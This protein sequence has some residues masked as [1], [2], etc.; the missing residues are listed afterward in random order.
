M[1]NSA[2]GR[3]ALALLAAALLAFAAGWAAHDGG[4][5]DWLERMTVDARFSLRGRQAPPASVVVVGIDENSLGQLPRFPFPRIWHARAIDAL[6]RAG[7][8]LIV[9]DVAFDRASDQ[10]DDNALKQAARQAAPV[11]F[12]TSEIGPSGATEVLE[13]N[14]ALAAIGARAAAADLPYDGDGVLRHTLDQI[15]HLPTVAAAVARQLHVPVDERQLRGG[16]IDFPGRPGTVR[17]LSFA[18]V[19]RGH[20][21]PAAVRGKIVVVGATAPAL[22]DLHATAV[23]GSP[24]PGPEVQADAIATVLRRFPLRSPPHG[25]TLALIALLALLVPLAGVRLGTLGTALA[26]VGAFALW[27]LAAQLAFDAGTVLDYADPLLALV[28]ATGGTIALS[29]WHDGRERARLREAFAANA[30]GVVESVLH[31]TGQRP[32]EPTAII[33]GYRIEAT[34]GRGGMGVVYRASQLALDR[35]VAIKLIA[36]ERSHDPVFR[37]RFQLES[38]I[39]ASI[40]HP[41]VIPVYE[42]GDDDG[43]LFIAMRLVDGVDL[44][45]LLCAA[46]ALAPPRALRIVEQLAGALDAAHTR[47]LVHRDVKPAN[48]LIAG[49]GSEHVYLT[50]FGVAKHIGTGAGVTRAEEWVGTLDYLA[51][52]QI[53]GDPVD[54]AADV[55]ALAGLLHHALTGTVPFPRDNQPAKLWAHLN[56]PPPSPRSV[57]PELPASLDGVMARG[58]AKHPGA[59]YATATDLTVACAHALGQ[60]RQPTTPPGRDALNRADATKSAPTEARTPPAA[61]ASDSGAARS[62]QTLQTEHADAS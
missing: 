53:R 55:Y 29:L 40:E 44:A 38:R 45:Q 39:A 50:D 6:H 2:R 3:R 51:P 57:R 10:S 42:A 56:A 20:F 19:L 32:L 27:S 62:A 28:L 33:A 26:G 52:E 21:D 16:W 58:M 13:G 18:Q 61:P 59:R 23:G 12:V 7:A 5:L 15:H 48:A 22:H 36:P 54:G 9:Y 17:N 1:W 31:P 46:G 24:M 30:T 35:A 49:D 47:G 25:T 37:E 14:A 4:L 8:R 43:L 11:I 34:I 60:P 41:H